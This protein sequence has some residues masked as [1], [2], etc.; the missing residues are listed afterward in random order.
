MRRSKFI[1]GAVATTWAE[2]FVAKAVAKSGGKAAASLS[3]K[4]GGA[5]LFT[6]TLCGVSRVAQPREP[7]TIV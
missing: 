3:P 5:S 7:T 4:A 1:V 6:E 2:G